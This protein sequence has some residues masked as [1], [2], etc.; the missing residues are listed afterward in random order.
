MASGYFSWSIMDMSLIINRHVYLINLIFLYWSQNFKC[1]AIKCQVILKIPLLVT[2]RSTA[3]Q[4]LSDGGYCHC[5]TR[6]HPLIKPWH[7]CHLINIS[8][9][10][11]LELSLVK[12]KQIKLCIF[13]N[14]V[15]LQ[16]QNI[17]NGYRMEKVF[18]N[19]A[20][21]F[22]I[23][24]SKLMNCRMLPKITRCKIPTPICWMNMI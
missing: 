15:I 23:H 24:K 19:F 4:S 12:N 11:K 8:V 9:F 5:W 2:V 17:Q 6:L 22:S 3:L 7:L 16:Q 13:Q 14:N 21:L 1:P 20:K 18:A 10:L